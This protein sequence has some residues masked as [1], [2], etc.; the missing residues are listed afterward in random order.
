MPNVR[1]GP[2][3]LS[4]GSQMEKRNHESIA[5]NQGGGELQT[6]WQSNDYQII[7][8]KDIWPR[9][10]PQIFDFL[11]FW[12]FFESW[13]LGYKQLHDSLETIRHT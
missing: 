9:L 10:H 12:V 1:S 5:K 7:Q 3:A 8:Q 4:L 2:C 13:T 6:E 11:C